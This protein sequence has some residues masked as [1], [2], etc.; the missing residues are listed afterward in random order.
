[1]DGSHFCTEVNHGYFELF[2]CWR[3][4]EARQCKPPRDSMA[5]VANSDLDEATKNHMPHGF[6]AWEDQVARILIA[7]GFVRL[8][9][10][11][12]RPLW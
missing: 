1:M 6:V 5:M 2:L 3:F 10:K 12:A 9:K 4:G 7:V 8:P 11:V